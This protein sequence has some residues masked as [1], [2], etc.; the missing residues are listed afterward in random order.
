M[1][2]DLN[3]LLHSQLRLAVISFLTSKGEPAGF[4]ELKEITKATSGNLSV[5]LKKLEGTGYVTI[6]KGFLSNYPHTTVEITTAGIEAFEQY[7]KA[8]KG[9]IE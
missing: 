8:L 6:K 4:N 5:Q 9:Y 3:P 7:V 2:K 1:F